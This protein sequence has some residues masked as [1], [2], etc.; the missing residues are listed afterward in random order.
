MYEVTRV[1]RG[2][3]LTLRSMVGGPAQVRQRDRMF[4]M[5][6]SRLDIVIGRLLPDGER[7][8]DGSWYLR[9]LGLMGTLDRS[10][11]KSARDLFTGGPVVPGTDP[12][13][14]VRLV[15]QFAPDGP[16]AVTTADGEEYLSCEATID[17]AGADDAW[18]SLTR[19]CLL[20]PEP[21]VRDLAGYDAFIAGVP[22]RFWTRNSET[23]IEY[24]GLLDGGQLTN[25]GTI[26][27][28]R[29]G[30]Q[31]TANSARRTAD[32]I[33]VVLGAA[34]AAG[35]SGKVTR[36]SAKTAVEL[37]GESGEDDGAKGREAM[38]RW[39]GLDAALAAVP[40]REVILEEH[41]LPIDHVP[42]IEMVAAEI[43]RE[44]TLRSM[45]EAPGYDGHTPAE[46]LKLGGAARDEVL[47]TIADSEWRLAH[48][49]AETA[50][51]MPR[52]ADIRRRLG[53]R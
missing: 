11:R 18:D 29:R 27:R 44:L 34:A 14:P 42:G 28:T 25:L 48:A 21:P 16:L 1:N 41:F 49:D 13:F 35:R 50:P 15:S 43:E 38:C 53:I 4:S 5:S 24:V 37:I 46:A 39:L 47:A 32:L 51:L 40:S 30:F 31:V 9:S 22:S 23:E 7:L 52:P 45:L 33:A 10:R 19:E 6:A 8:P 36:Q 3:E 26:V 12:D 17:V 20:A 2:S